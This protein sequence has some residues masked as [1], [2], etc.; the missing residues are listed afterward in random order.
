M[1]QPDDPRFLDQWNLYDPT[2]AGQ[3]VTPDINAPTAWDVTTGTS[4]TIIAILDSGVDLDHPDLASKI[5]VN[6]DE[7]P[8]NGVDDDGNGKVDDVNGWDFVDNDNQPQDESGWG[9]LM[10]GIAGAATNN[11][12]GVASI[13]WNSPV[14]PVRILTRDELGQARARMDDIV[15]GIRYAVDN[16]ARIIHIGLYAESLTPDQRATLEAAINAAHDEGVLIVAPVGEHGLADNPTIYPA[17][18]QA[19]MGVTATDQKKE[20]LSAAGHGS[21]V[22]VAAPGVNLLSTLPD[23]R[24]EFQ[25]GGTQLAAAHVSGTAALIWAVNPT[26]TADEVR[27]L[28]RENADDLG[29]LGYDELYGFGLLN[30]SL[31]VS[32]TPH[33]LQINPRELHFEVD[34]FGVITPPTQKVVN[35]NTSGLTWQAQT[36][37]RWLVIEGLAETTPSSVTVSVDPTKIPNC[38]QYAG[39][40]TIQSNQPNQVDGEQSVDVTLE[41]AQATCATTHLPLLKR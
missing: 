29:A 28:I 13:A 1:A 14:M 19:V 15:A 21:F 38:G 25:F 22:D 17:A 16:G 18:F 7:T 23:N 35:A 9:T 26:L 40:I 8:A 4:D 32:A 20:R 39:T 12:V 37:A 30:A 36:Q 34:E 3:D 31:A 6:D 2:S 41:F 24:Y 11:G 10:A 5:W 27:E 33:L